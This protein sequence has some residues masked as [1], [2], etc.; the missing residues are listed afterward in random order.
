MDKKTDL[1]GYLV[2]TIFGSAPG[3]RVSRLTKLVFV[4]DK[5]ALRKD[6]ERFAEYPDLVRLVVAHE[7]V[8]KGPEAASALKTAATYL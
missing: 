2:T 4:K 1:L 6:L 7:K 3:P 5:K 8:A